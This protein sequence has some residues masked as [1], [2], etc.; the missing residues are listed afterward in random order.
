MIPEGGGE[1]QLDDMTE[2]RSLIH[3][4]FLIFYTGISSFLLVFSLLF[5]SLWSLSVLY[6]A[7]LV[8][9]WDTPSQGECWKRAMCWEMAAGCLQGSLHPYV[10][11]L[12]WKAIGVDEELDRLE[13]PKGLLSSQGDWLPSRKTVCLLP[14]PCLLHLFT[15]SSAEA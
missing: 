5:T 8:L 2:F 10:S 11:P 1:E 9:D 14:L 3:F 15:P 4:Y 7:W 12:R 13:T 6:L